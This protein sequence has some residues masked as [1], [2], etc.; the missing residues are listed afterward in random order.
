MNLLR[1]VSTLNELRLWKLKI[2]QSFNNTLYLC[3][4]NTGDVST[5]KSLPP[6]ATAHTLLTFKNCNWGCELISEPSSC[7]LLH[8]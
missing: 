1:I 8:K 6:A 4:K 5:I 7:V 3:N 2:D